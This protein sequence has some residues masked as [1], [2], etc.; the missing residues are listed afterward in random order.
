MHRCSSRSD[1]RGGDCAAS[2]DSE[3]F[4]AVRVEERHALQL[5]AT[6]LV[7]VTWMQRRTRHRRER[8]LAFDLT[9]LLHT[10]K[11]LTKV[12]VLAPA[13][14]EQLA[15]VR[16]HQR[17]LAAACDGSDTSHGPEGN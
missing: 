4:E 9:H 12:A 2:S 5:A 16:G 14:A 8:E 11:L 13:A 10:G 6:L 15:V 3:H 17:V 7:P 1:D